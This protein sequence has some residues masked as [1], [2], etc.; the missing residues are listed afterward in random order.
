MFRHIAHT[1]T[2]LTLAAIGSL[3]VSAGVRPARAQDG[4]RYAA[5]IPFAF[6]IDN[7]VFPRGDVSIH[8]TLSAHAA[9]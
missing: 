4:P 3:L 7:A 9:P 1:A 2:S 5:T 8:S 6:G